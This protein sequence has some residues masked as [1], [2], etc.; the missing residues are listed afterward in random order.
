MISAYNEPWGGA[1]EVLN[2]SASSVDDRP[3]T[4]AVGPA[5]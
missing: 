2:S 5:A 3:G 1:N 4:R